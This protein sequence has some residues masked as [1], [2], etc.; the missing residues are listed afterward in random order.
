MKTTTETRS[1]GKS[2]AAARQ[3]RRALD[4]AASAGNYE[5][6]REQMIA[7]AAYFRAERRGFVPGNEMTDWL[8]AEAD[9]ESVLRSIQ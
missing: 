8:E 9:V 7:E 6:P 5:C 2:N 4:P 1:K 3:P